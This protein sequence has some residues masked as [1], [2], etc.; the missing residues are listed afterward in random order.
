MLLVRRLAGMIALAVLM[1]PTA[2]ASGST[3]HCGFATTGGWRISQPNQGVAA[4]ACE[5]FED[6]PREN[7]QTS[8]ALP[9]ASTAAGPARPAPEP[10]PWCSARS[11]GERSDAV[12]IFVEHVPCYWYSALPGDDGPERPQRAAPA[13]PAAVLWDRARALAPAPALRIAPAHIGLTGM[14]TY[15]WLA[16]RPRPIAA[17]ARAGGISATATARPV[18]Y[19]WDFGDG[20][21]ITTDHPGHPWSPQRDGSIA[22]VYETKGRYRISVTTVWEARWRAGGA[23]IPLGRFATTGGRGFP[24][25]EMITVLVPPRS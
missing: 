25:R 12:P 14:E 23:W 16:R 17:G 21:T 13:N 8:A 4:E 9:A 15:V 2:S 10:D 1:F 5:A 20:T 6:L 3:H 22:H 7:D 24:V 19:V 18:R 11:D